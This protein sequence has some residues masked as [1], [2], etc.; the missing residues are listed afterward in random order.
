M[1]HVAEIEARAAVPPVAV[2]AAV[3][4]RSDGAILLSLRPKNAHQGGLWEF[5]GGKIEPGERPVQA[6]VRELNEELGIAINLALPLIRIEHSYSDKQ[7]DLHVFEGLDWGGIPSGREGQMIAWVE[8]AKLAELKVPAANVP[9]RTAVCLPHLSLITTLNNND[10][11]RYLERLEACLNGGIKLVQLSAGHDA[12]ADLRRTAATAVALCAEFGAKL[13]FSAGNGDLLSDG[14]HGLH[15]PVDCLRQ[16]S[17][18]PIC[19]NLLLSA[20]CHSDADVE[21]A[22]RIGADFV[23]LFPPLK[24]RAAVAALE[25]D[26]NRLAATVRRARIPV[27][28]GGGFLAEDIGIAR[29]LGYQGIA[30]ESCALHDEPWRTIRLCATALMRSAYSVTSS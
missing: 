22:T 18:R 5:P 8:P 27:F 13:L 24:K 19:S 12:S 20:C 1:R 4:R 30:L 21:Q 28:A 15:L 10:Q 14:A 9:I 6:L 16:L 11:H 25:V 2:A 29:R 17:E 7:V 23:Y 3:I 26:R